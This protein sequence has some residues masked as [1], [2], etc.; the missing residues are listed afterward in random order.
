[1]AAS[2]PL[3]YD[4]DTLHSLHGRPLL[5]RYL[6]SYPTRRGS[7]RRFPS[8]PARMISIT[9][10]PSG[11]QWPCGKACIPTSLRA[12]SNSR[13]DGLRS[14]LCYRT[15]SIRSGGSRFRPLRGNTGS[16]ALGSSLDISSC[17]AA[18]KGGSLLDGICYRPFASPLSSQG[19]FPARA[20][21]APCIV[22]DGLSSI[23]SKPCYRMTCKFA[24]ANPE[25]FGMRI[26]E[27]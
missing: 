25:P 5:P 19:S 21:S 13:R 23:G 20:V 18:S 7:S 22:P 27:G 14:V 8:S 16:P 24:A 9:T 3:S 2:S 26:P 1:M 11:N 10:L 6:V 12:A 17:A 15:Q 4:P